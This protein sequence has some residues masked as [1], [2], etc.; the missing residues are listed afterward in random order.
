MNITSELSK[1]QSLLNDVAQHLSYY[2]R[3]DEADA[4]WAGARSITVINT[5]QDE[6]ATTCRKLV[7]YVEHYHEGGQASQNIDDRT[8]RENLLSTARA[9]VGHPSR[10]TTRSPLTTH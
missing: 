2:G 3:E 5:Y 10:F 8:R 6:V 7:P 1:I 9:L 4:C